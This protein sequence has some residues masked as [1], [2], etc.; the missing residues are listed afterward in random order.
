MHLLL[1]RKALVPGHT[2]HTADGRPVTVRPYV[3]RTPPAHGAPPTVT[4]YRSGASAPNIMRGYIV[5]GTPFGVSLAELSPGSTS[6]DMMIGYAQR[7]GRVFVDSGAFTSFTKGQPTNWP[8]LVAIW[9]RL[10]QEARG[11][12]MAVVGPDVIGDQAASL[13]L[14]A[15]HRDVVLEMIA[16]GLDVLIPVQK[17][18][19]PPY[20]AWREAVRILGTAD[21]TAS[22]PS[23]AAAFTPADLADLFDGPEKPARVHLLGIAG[24][25]K[26]LAPLLHVVQSRSPATTITT[27]ANRL[28][29]QVG[30]G[31]PV[32]D[33][34]P[35]WAAELERMFGVL[36]QHESPAVQAAW[37][38]AD[39]ASVL[40]PAI[41]AGSIAQVEA[42]GRARR[43]A[44][45]DLFLLPKG[46]R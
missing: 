22:V 37:A 12:R 27:D 42:T 46:R 4:S 20:H 11:T 2:R 16:A 23:N 25:T 18:D 39:K 15:E 45:A 3:T 36:V 34:R 1:L 29:A 9:R 24:N 19:M 31:R 43:E 7:G 14:L 21:F 5:G 32:T 13:R 40:A 33:A 35:K 8:K 30:Q 17:G 26:R 28:R 10:A 44:Q 41:A 6:W 38:A